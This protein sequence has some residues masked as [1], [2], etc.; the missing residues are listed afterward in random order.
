MASS[1]AAT[2]KA[3]ERAGM[4]MITPDQGVEAFEVFLHNAAQSVVAAVPFRWVQLFSRATVTPFFLHSIEESFAVSNSSFSPHYMSQ[5][6]I[7][8]SR[9]CDL[10]IP[11]LIAKQL[12]DIMLN[13]LDV[14][15]DASQPLMAAGLDSLGKCDASLWLV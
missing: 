12:C 2:A 11:T 6:Q 15:V 7:G 10:D 4:G 13:M 1:S 8:G 3:V 5:N 14:P 9:P